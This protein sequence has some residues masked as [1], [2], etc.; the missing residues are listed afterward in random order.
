MDVHSRN[1]LSING[2][3][4]HILDFRRVLK[5]SEDEESS[6]EQEVAEENEAVPRRSQRERRQP[7]WMRDYVTESDCEQK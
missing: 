6:D 7:V 5:P 1:N 3:P 4:R 2:M